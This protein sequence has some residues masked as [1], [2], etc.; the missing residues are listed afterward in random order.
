MRLPLVFSILAA[1]AVTTATFSFSPAN[2][3]NRGLFAVA[4]AT[5]PPAPRKK[6]ALEPGVQIACTRVGCNPIP[7]GCHIEKE[8]NWDGLPTGYDLVVC[9]S[10]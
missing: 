10:R 1:A 2:A 3:N 8:F 5:Q 9:P 7:K 6:R 4:Q